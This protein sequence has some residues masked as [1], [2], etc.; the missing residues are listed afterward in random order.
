MK[1]HFKIQ[2]YQS[3]A[4]DAVAK[5]FNGQ[6]FHEKISYILHEMIRRNLKSFLYTFTNR[7]AR[8]NNNKF[9]PAVTLM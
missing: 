6:G 5:V 8:Y 1:F 2:Q 7:N 4:V 9:A 3:D